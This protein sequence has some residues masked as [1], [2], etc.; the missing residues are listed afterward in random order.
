[1]SKNSYPPPSE[2][3]CFYH[4]LSYHL[5]KQK[6]RGSSTSKLQN[7]RNLLFACVCEEWLAV[8]QVVMLKGFELT[9]LSAGT[10]LIFSVLIQV[11]QMS[12]RD[13][14]STIFTKLIPFLCKGSYGL[15]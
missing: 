1:M 8:A 7:F 11:D 3:L 5:Q 2:D 6:Q 4:D 12:Q 9:I 10:M 15:R 13:R 14:R